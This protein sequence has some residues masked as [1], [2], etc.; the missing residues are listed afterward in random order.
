MKKIVFTAII[1]A[2]SVTF[3][4]CDWFSTKKPPIHSS[5]VGVWKVDSLFTSKQDSNYLPLLYFAMIKS[6]SIFIQ[7]N[8]DSTYRELAKRDSVL[9]KYYVKGHQVFLQQDSI[10]VPYQLSFPK[11]SVAQLISKDSLVIVLKKK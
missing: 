7:F 10:Y 11:D 6:N 1:I 3:F 5:I 4:S 2:L 9:N 8:A